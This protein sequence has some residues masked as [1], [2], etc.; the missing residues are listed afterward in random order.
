M[1]RYQ[2]QACLLAARS[3]SCRGAAAGQYGA[4]P[5]EVLAAWGRI[6][7]CATAAEVQQVLADYPIPLPPRLERSLQRRQRKQIDLFGG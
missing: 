2:Q 6:A 7:A 4:D 5:S 1:N 3:L